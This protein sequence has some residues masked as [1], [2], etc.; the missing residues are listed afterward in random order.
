MFELTINGA[1]YK[2]KFGI[3]FMREMN[4][5]QK[6]TTNGITKEIGLQ[7]GIAGIIDGDIEDLIT[8]LDVSNK[9][10]EPRVTKELIE[11]YIEDSNTDI[12]ALFTKVLDFLKE[13]NVTRKLT[14]Q[15]LE[16]VEAEKA[17]N[18]N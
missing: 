10:E 9:T 1:V 7:M 17:K 5:K 12:D 18:Q 15:L 3:G 14:K 16:M 4:K 13:A 11:T 8:I 2:F 6:Q